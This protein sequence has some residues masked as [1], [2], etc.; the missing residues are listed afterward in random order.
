MNLYDLCKK[1]PIGAI[2]FVSIFVNTPSWMNP[3]ETAKDEDI[4]RITRKR[5]KK[6]IQLLACRTGNWVASNKKEMPPEKFV[7]LTYLETKIDGSVECP[8][9]YCSVRYFY[10]EDKHLI[11]DWKFVTPELQTAN[12]ICLPSKKE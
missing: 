7:K 9:A 10:H 3:D 12:G 6:C 11:E 2:L 5:F 4:I 8:D 1:F